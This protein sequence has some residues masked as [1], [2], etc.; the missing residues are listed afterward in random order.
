LRSCW[1]KLAAPEVTAA[2]MQYLMHNGTDLS[3]ALLGLTAKR[4]FWKLLEQTKGVENF[5]PLM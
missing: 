2:A 4:I 1:D 5:E 3:N